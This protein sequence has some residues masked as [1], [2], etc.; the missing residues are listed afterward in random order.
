MYAIPE[1]SYNFVY[2]ISFN[3]Y[4]VNQIGVLIDMYLRILDEY[5]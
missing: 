5:N 4:Q 3:W 2:Y 1:T